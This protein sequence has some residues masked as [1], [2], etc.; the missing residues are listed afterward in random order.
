MVRD[1]G[2][3]EPVA[4][5]TPDR[6]VRTASIGKL[7][8]LLCAAEELAAGEQDPDEPLTPGPDD[9]VADSGLWYLMRQPEL[10]FADACLLVGAVSDN[11]ATN[12]LIES[13]GLEAVHEL[14]RRLGYENSALLDKVRNDRTPDLPPTLSYG[15][16]TELSDLMCRLAGGPSASGGASG[17]VGEGRDGGGIVPEVRELVNGWL[18]TDTDM[19]MVAG[20]FGLDPLAHVEADAGIVLRHKTGTISDARCDV[21]WARSQVTGRGVAWAVLVNWP[22]PEST[23]ESEFSGAVLDPCAAPT[24]DAPLTAEPALRDAGM[25]TRLAVLAAMRR[26][27]ESLARFVT[28]APASPHP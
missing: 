5:L 18:A 12:V 2:T 4:R 16:A 1:L 15:S 6:V 26:L 7:F 22:E 3:G 17:L 19:S 27:G 28:A 9:E 14:T 25:P 21:G 20:G 13:L 8:L 24:P 10:R 23:P 11:R